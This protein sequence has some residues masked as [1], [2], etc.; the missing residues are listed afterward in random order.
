MLVVLL[1]YWLVQSMG[2]A[3]TTAVT[4]TTLSPD[5]AIV[6]VWSPESAYDSKM[7][8]VE[9]TD[10]DKSMKIVFYENHTATVIVGGLSLGDTDWSY[11][12]TDKD[13]NMFYSTNN[14]EGNFEIVG[15]R[16][17]YKEHKGK[18]II[19]EDDGKVTFLTKSEEEQTDSYK[20][21]SSIDD[22]M[23]L[24]D[25]INSWADK[26]DDMDT[27]GSTITS[28]KK[29]ALKKADEYL[30]LK[31]FSYSKLVEQLEYEGFSPTEA[32]YAANNCG[33]DW[34]EQAARKATEY[35]NLKSFSRSKLIEQL[36]YEGFTHEQAVYG[37]N[38]AY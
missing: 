17:K 3:V 6:G 31:G 19:E 1:V 10:D 33:A 25:S 2:K 35:L 18:I 38:K 26:L 7:N 22:L 11:D 20:T 12:R 8:E 37:V 21:T 29:N 27:D 14:G 5:E 23:D 9:L 15:P 34:N 30:N 4:G 32:V 16:G 24:V 13:G 28:G 36:E